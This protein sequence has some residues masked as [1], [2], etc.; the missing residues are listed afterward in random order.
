MQG[1]AIAVPQAPVQH[2]E[3][4]VPSRVLNASIIVFIVARKIAHF[5]SFLYGIQII[6]FAFALYFAHTVIVLADGASTYYSSTGCTITSNDAATLVNST[7]LGIVTSGG[8]IFG[9]YSYHRQAQTGRVKSAHE[10][11][12]AFVADE[13]V[14]SG[15]H[16]VEFFQMHTMTFTKSG[17]S[18]AL[19][20]FV[21]DRRARIVG[22]KGS[23]RVVTTELDF[24]FALMPHN[25]VAR[26]W[27]RT[28]GTLDMTSYQENISESVWLFLRKLISFA[29]LNAAGIMNIDDCPRLRYYLDLIVP[30]SCDT[31]V[32]DEPVASQLRFFRHWC[33]AVLMWTYF[34]DQ[35]ALDDVTV[36]IL[37]RFI[38][39]TLVQ[40]HQSLCIFLFTIAP[41]E[42]GVLTLRDNVVD[43]YVD[44]LWAIRAE[45]PLT[46]TAAIERHAS[47]IVPA[48]YG[49]WRTLLQTAMPTSL[50]SQ[51]ERSMHVQSS[52][53]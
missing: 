39:R 15:V 35:H 40:R 48:L 12:D 25:D 41:M 11:L 27:M 32:V 6:G 26:Y 52:L 45:L 1:G 37:R 30:A 42:G 23:M 33:R 16:A 47:T 21:R 51:I 34:T 13:A 36:R 8:A 24:A 18:Q 17:G 38:A 46:Q 22:K 53:Y 3:G 7:F 9:L 4:L 43:Q 20:Q 10:A 44:A 50:R 31:P 14:A 28:F 19:R 49:T 29:E 2:F 5:I